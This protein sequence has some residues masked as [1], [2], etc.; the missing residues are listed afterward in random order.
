MRKMS[1]NWLLNMNLRLL[2]LHWLNRCKMNIHLIKKCIDSDIHF[3]SLRYAIKESFLPSLFGSQALEADIMCRLSRYESIGILGLVKSAPQFLILNEAT[4]F[5]MLRLAL[6]ISTE[7][8]NFDLSPSEFRDGLALCY[9]IVGKIFTVNPALN[10][11]YEESWIS[12][13]WNL[14]SSI[15]LFPN[16]LVLKVWT[17]KKELIGLPESFWSHK[18]KLFLIFVFSI[19]KA[20][21]SKILLLECCYIRASFTHSLPLVTSIWY[22]CWFIHQQVSS[23]AQLKMP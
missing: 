8:N 14:Q 5:R 23:Y 13:Y 20:F 11:S 18:N 4:S 10:C 12:H 16:K 17:R 22:R 19:P 6:C 15:K 7:R 2:L 21:P 9:H 3:S 1:A